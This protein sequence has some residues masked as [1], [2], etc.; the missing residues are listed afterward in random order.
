MRGHF[1]RV[2]GSLFRVSIVTPLTDLQSLASYNY[3]SGLPQRRRGGWQERGKVK[4]GWRGR[5]EREGTGTGRRMHPFA[6]HV[7]Q[8]VTFLRLRT[9]K[10]P[11]KGSVRGEKCRLR[12]MFMKDDSLQISQSRTSLR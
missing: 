9:A 5:W 6:D 1:G 12:Q 10:C 11:A 2:N 7:S 4:N 3:E 8:A